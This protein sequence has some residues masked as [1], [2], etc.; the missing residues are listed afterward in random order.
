MTRA[1]AAVATTPA[2]SLGAGRYLDAAPEPAGTSTSVHRLTTSDGAVVEGVLRRIPGAHSVVC[3]MHPR[4]SLVHHALIPELLAQGFAVWVQNSRSVN[5]DIALIH[6][7]AILDLAAGQVWLREQGFESVVTLGHS[8]GA[9]LSA[10]YYEQ[11]ALEPGERLQTT[12]GG[13][14]TK[15]AEA[16]MPL[17]DAT[18]FL[19]PHPGQGALL[20]RIIDPSV[21]AESDPLSVDPAL[22][23]F[24]PAN[25]FV[26]APS[27]SHYTA[28]FITRYHAAQRDRVERID[29]RARELIAE[30]AAW[31]ARHREGS[32]PRDKRG[33][34]APR[35]ITVY[36]TDADLRSMDQSIDANDRPYGSLMGSRPDLTD[37]GLVGFGRFSTPEAWLSTWSVRSSNAN[38]LRCAP[39][40]TA[41][42]LLL[43]FTGDQAA[44]PEDFT[45][46]RAALGASDL[47]FERIRGTHFGAALEPGETSGYTLAGAT[48]G[49]WL[50]ERVGRA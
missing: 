45:E 37:Y 44:F 47:E 14:P 23:P 50:G 17:P 22:D 33:S 6:E 8:G 18:I 28:D 38:F 32:D 2:E 49:D 16:Q 4:Q 12:P 1:S 43:E 27:S 40:V 34:L 7:R 9:T 35:V 10:F 3:L 26:E 25:G 31:R 13:Q 21:T 48:I 20:A 39:A 15:L 46:M 19:A 36:R 30:S 42:T 24:D 5:N 11:A 29:A 41:P